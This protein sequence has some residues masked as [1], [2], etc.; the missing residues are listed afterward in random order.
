[1]TGE[2]TE[3]NKMAGSHY[4]RRNLTDKLGEN[5]IQTENIPAIK[6][7]PSLF[8][9]FSFHDI[10]VTYAHVCSIA[11]SI[12]TYEFSCVLLSR[13]AAKNLCT[14]HLLLKEEAKIGCCGDVQS[15]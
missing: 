11:I 1:M 14:L 7:T 4:L 15:L 8:K 3:K 6:L 10:Y 2:L 5:I 9:I 12:E 13:D